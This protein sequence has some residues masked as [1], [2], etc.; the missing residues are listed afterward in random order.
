MR[1]SAAAESSPLESRWATRA[2]TVFFGASAA[3]AAGC[4]LAVATGWP[5]LAV[6]PSA[7]AFGTVV[8]GLAFFVGSGPIRGRTAITGRVGVAVALGVVVGELAAVALF[9]GAVDRAMDVSAARAADAVPAVAQ[10]AADLDG[11]RAA[12]AEL[13]AAVDQSRARLDQALIVAR[14]EYNPSPAC[15]LTRITG[16]PGLGPET[17]TANELLAD[18]RRELDSAVTARERQAPE[19]DAAVGDNERMLDAARA[20]AVDAADRGLGARWVTMN[21]YTQSKPGALFLRILTDVFF[22]LLSLL[23]LILTLL[24]GQTVRG[25]RAAADA[26]RELAELEADTA[27]AVKRA[28]VRRA[29]EILWAEQQLA[30]ARLAVEAQHEIDRALH[31]RRVAQAVNGTVE[32]AAASGNVADGESDDP[33]QIAA[34]ASERKQLTSSGTRGVAPA[35]PVRS[36]ERLPAPVGAEIAERGG[37]RLIPS[38]PELTTSAARW[39]RPLVP[40]ILAKA[41]DSTVHPVRTARQVFEEVEEIHLSLRRTHTVTVHSM[42]NPDPVQ[43]PEPAGVSPAVSGGFGA[44]A[45]GHPAPAGA[46]MSRQGDVPLEAGHGSGRELPE[47]DGVRQLPPG[48]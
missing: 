33:P 32:S 40:T 44:E 36:E 26:E 37:P 7:L 13:D 1:A 39:V 28:D 12:R 4:V 2:V 16:T 47:P 27:I 9:A 46:V 8:A 48:K 25:R 5:R 24:R 41:I 30:N 6:V 3:L 22:V 17:L 21:D 29:A 38:L 45:L 11:S 14:C 23:P 18:A 10:A 20:S 15:P 42:D 34:D 19:L 43:E 35:L 31:R